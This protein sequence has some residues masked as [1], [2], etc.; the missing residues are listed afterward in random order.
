MKVLMILT[1][2][3]SAEIAIPIANRG[4]RG[5]S[6][7]ERRAVMTSPTQSRTEPRASVTALIKVTGL[8]RHYSFRKNFLTVPEMP[9]DP[10]YQIDK[11]TGKDDDQSDAAVIDIL[12]FAGV[13][14]PCMTDYLIDDI[15]HSYL[16]TIIV[17]ITQGIVAKNASA[18]TKIKA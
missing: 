11:D 12:L 13:G 4:R 18:R 16:L 15:V 7:P 2:S 17:R 10:V 1:P 14:S 9:K 3:S 8:C 6:S 5:A